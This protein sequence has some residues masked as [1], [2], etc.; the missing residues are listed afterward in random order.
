[1]VVGDGS[2]AADR[3]LEPRRSLPENAILSV[4]AGAL[5]GSF[6]LAT[7]TRRV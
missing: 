2:Q 4:W 1:M 5:E 6:S 3:G 7:F